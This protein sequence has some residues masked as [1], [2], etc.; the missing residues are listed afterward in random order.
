MPTPIRSCWTCAERWTRCRHSASTPRHRR[1][2]PRCVPRGLMAEI[3]R[4]QRT[5]QRTHLMLANRD[6]R[7]HLLS[8]HREMMIDERHARRMMKIPRNPAKKPCSRG[9]RT[10]LFQ[11]SGRELN[12][13][14]L[15]CERSALPTE[16]PPRIAR[17]LVGDGGR[18]DSKF[19]I[20][21]KAFQPI[22]GDVVSC[23]QCQAR[24]ARRSGFDELVSLPIPVA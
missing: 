12:P 9:L 3:F 2:E 23:H 17:R 16:L 19:A 21:G 7:V 6:F 15:H 20:E 13:R 8:S 22:D 10:R 24:H 18:E 4:V 11:W 14:P 1:I 5:H